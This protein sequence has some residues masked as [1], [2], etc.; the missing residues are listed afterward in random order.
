MTAY[1][2]ANELLADEFAAWTRAGA[3]TLADYLL[4]LEEE[5]GSEMEFCRVAIRCDY[6][7]YESAEELAK[8]YDVEIPEGG[9]A[10]EV[11]KEHFEGLTTLLEIPNNGGFIIASHF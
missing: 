10:D 1:E 8:A 2:I 3:F 4:D 11:V 6:S 7:E 9:D 5:T